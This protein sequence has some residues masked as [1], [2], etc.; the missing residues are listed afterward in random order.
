MTHNTKVN[1]SKKYSVKY[2]INKIYYVNELKVKFNMHR[3]WTS[4]MYVCEYISGI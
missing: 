3:V 4:E 2:I 1:N